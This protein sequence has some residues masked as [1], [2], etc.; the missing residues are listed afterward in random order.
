VL[1]GGAVVLAVADFVDAGGDTAFDVVL[2]TRPATLPGDRLVARANPEQPMRER[3]RFPCERR[4]QERACVEMIVALD[5]ARHEHARELFAGRQLQVGI[6]LVVA[7]QDVVFRDSL[8]DQV[9]FERERFDD[10]VGDDDL[11]VLRFVEERV[12]SR[13]H[14]VRAEV[15]AYAVSQHPCFADVQSFARPV[16]I[17][18]NAGLLRQAGDLGLE[19]TDRHALQCAFWR[20]TEPFI[21]ARS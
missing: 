11:E 10:R 20:K 21:I 14:A 19:I 18:V 6:I 12:D 13:T 16:V 2:E 5:A 1:D 3:H 7:K 8:L 17:Q 4:R 15:A 9:V